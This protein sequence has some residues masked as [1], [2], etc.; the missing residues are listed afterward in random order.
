MMATLL[1]QSKTGRTEP[2]E[3]AGALSPRQGHWNTSSRTTNRR[4][5]RTRTPSLVTTAPQLYDL[6]VDP[7]A[8]QNL[9][10]RY[11][12]RVTAMAAALDGLRRARRSR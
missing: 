1:G 8:M 9:A 2:V 3:E 7:G 12:A 5:T 6:A 10:P 4:S 11:P